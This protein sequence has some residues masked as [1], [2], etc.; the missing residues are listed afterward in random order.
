MKREEFNRY[1]LPLCKEKKILDIGCIG[2]AEEHRFGGT[3][4]R[5]GK[6]SEVADKLIGIDIQRKAIEKIKRKGYDVRYANVQNLDLDEKFDIILLMELIEHVENPGIVLEKVRKHLVKR[7]LMVV[8]SPNAFR[9][10]N[11]LRHWRKITDGNPEHVAHYTPFIFKR[12]ASR[13]GFKEKRIIWSS[14]DWR[15]SQTSKGKIFSLLLNSILPEH[16]CAGGWMG[17]YQKVKQS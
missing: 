13:F 15:D 3:D 17:I 11:F 5:H 7:G 4:W 2:Q 9:Y 12:L 16:L 10:G 6:I 1:V 8:S 14:Y